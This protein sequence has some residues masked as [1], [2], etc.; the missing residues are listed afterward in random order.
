MDLNTVIHVGFP[1]TGTTTQQ[2]HLFEN[3]AQIVYLGKPYQDDRFQ[4]EIHHLIMQ[5][6]TIYQSSSLKEYMNSLEVQ[7]P[8]KK[9]IMISDEIMVSVSKVRDKGVVAQR[10]KD[11]FYPCKILITLR[12]QLDILMS[13]YISGCRL[14]T[15]VPAR[16]QGRFVALEDWLEYSYRNLERSHIGNFIYFNTIEYYSRLFG[17]DNVLVLLF[18]EFIH[19]KQDYIKKLSDFLT[20]DWQESMKLIE[21]AHDN[22]RIDQ[23]QFEFEHMWGGHLPIRKSRWISGA[24]KIYYLFRKMS[25]KNKKAKVV[26]PHHWTDRL[27]NIYKEGN[28]KLAESFN[29][30]LHEYGY[31]L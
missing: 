5:E 2:N 10:I 25:G 4:K 8:G 28:Q 3:H 17:K 12:N 7:D 14:L 16:Y 26:I 21:T 9:V 15:N 30:P 13:T 19:H 24:S 23:S 18:E 20:V 11:I 31:P 1:K 27:E 29:L 6:S 22:V